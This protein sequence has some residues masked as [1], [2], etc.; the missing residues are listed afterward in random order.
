MFVCLYIL[1]DED[2]RAIIWAD[3]N[4]LIKE[5]DGTTI[6]PAHSSPNLLAI[7]I[8]SAVPESQLPLSNCIS[9]TVQVTMGGRGGDP[10][11]L[12]SIMS[13]TLIDVDPANKPP[14]PNLND[15]ISPR[16]SSRQIPPFRKHRHGSRSAC[17]M[18]CMSAI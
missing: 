11:G 16:L 13:P 7:I 9:N 3:P 12:I 10:A 2:N 8:P 18:G 5:K 17:M 1:E 6:S 4:N 14:L 15:T